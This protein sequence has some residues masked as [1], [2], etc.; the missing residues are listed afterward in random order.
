MAGHWGSVE[1]CIHQW[2]EWHWVRFQWGLAHSHQNLQIRYQIQCHFLKL[3]LTLFWLLKTMH[4]NLPGVAQWIECRTV[5]WKVTGSIPSQGTCLDCGP[6]P[7]WGF[8]TLQEQLIHPGDIKWSRKLSYAHQLLTNLQNHKEVNNL[9]CFKLQ[10]FRMVCYMSLD[11]I[12]GVL[13]LI[14]I[15][16]FVTFPPLLIV[17]LSFT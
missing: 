8:S 11:K 16:V 13:L 14:K 15:R 10:S 4:V 5:N 9:Y 12:S 17:L 6:G 3:L 2:F 1:S 7:S